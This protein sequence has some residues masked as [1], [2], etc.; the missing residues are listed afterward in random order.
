MN[1]LDAALNASIFAGYA[2][3]QWLEV[4]GTLRNTVAS[5]L[6]YVLGVRKNANST[7]TI[8]AKLVRLVVATVLVRANKSRT[9]P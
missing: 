8:I 3:A 9:V 6:T 1:V 5:A 7:S 4:V 2:S